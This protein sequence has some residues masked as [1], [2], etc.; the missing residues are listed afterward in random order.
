MAK[1]KKDGK[2]KSKVK[3]ADCVINISEN[4]HQ[5][6]FSKIVNDHAVQVIYG[7]MF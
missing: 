4:N 7:N 5:I 3:K 6:I 2:G 1:I